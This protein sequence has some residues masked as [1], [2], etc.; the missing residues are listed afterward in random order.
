MSSQ[1]TLGAITGCIADSLPYPFQNTVAWTRQ[2]SAATTTASQ[3]LQACPPSTQS[4]IL[5]PNTST[6]GGNIECRCSNTA[7]SQ[8]IAT[9]GLT[10]FVDP[11][12][13]AGGCSLLCSD[14]SRCGGLGG[15]FVNGKSYSAAGVVYAV[16]AAPRTN[17]ASS[18]TS[19]GVAS[20]TAAPTSTT[21]SIDTATLN[22]STN[23]PDA[24]AS[25]NLSTA[26]PQPTTT[27]P[28]APASPDSDS[29]K[30]LIPTISGVVVLVLVV[31]VSLLIINYRRRLNGSTPS[32][33]PASSYKPDLE[34]TGPGSGAM[35]Y[36][37]K[38][39]SQN[40]IATTALPSASSYH[41]HYDPP[42]H[43][44]Q[45]QLHRSA[46]RSS[47]S[48][49][50][51]RRPSFAH[52]MQISEPMPPMPTAYPQMS[53]PVSPDGVPGTPVGSAMGT[54]VSAGGVVVPGSSM[55]LDPREVAET[56]RMNPHDVQAEMNG[57]GR[58]A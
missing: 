5:T 38:R 40:S 20:E 51:S 2:V 45:A 50:L 4:I 29:P 56:L 21:A 41:P 42:N 49:R 27:K 9:S 33:P 26:I 3:C 43:M 57:W 23:V 35:G 30:F 53:S 28:A 39:F 7:A 18:T 32:Y 47:M 11:G 58:R 6:G 34:E 46:S 17:A 36:N 1:G 10:L 12:N 31:V 44:Q 48:S 24:T 52:E 8:L 19:E 14:G 15:S 16:A 25:V 13:A 55:L 37:N 54:N 22:F